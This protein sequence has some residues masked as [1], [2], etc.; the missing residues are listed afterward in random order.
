VEAADFIEAILEAIEGGGFDLGF[1]TFCGR[2]VV[3]LADGMPVICR[4]CIPR[5]EDGG[6]QDEQAKAPR[7][8][9]GQDPR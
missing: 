6:G 9:D 2:P 1:C 5:L 3:Y 8:R 7:S 4:D